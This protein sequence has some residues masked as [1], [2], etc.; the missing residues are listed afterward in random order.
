MAVEVEEAHE[1]GDGRRQQ[2]RHHVVLPEVGRESWVETD[3]HVAALARLVA[4]DGAHDEEELAEVE[5][6]ARVG[7]DD[8][9]DLHVVPRLAEVLLLV[10]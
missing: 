9:E 8:D 6:D 2:E 7:H 3:E 1:A 5:D 4:L 10:L